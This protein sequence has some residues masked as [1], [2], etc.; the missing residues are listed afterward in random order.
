VGNP[1]VL[2]QPPRPDLSSFR[3]D[4]DIVTSEPCSGDETALLFLAV[5]GAR[6]LCAGVPRASSSR[7]IGVAA[8]ALGMAG[9]HVSDPLTGEFRHQLTEA[10]RNHAL[11]PADARER[12][13][14]AL[15]LTTD[16]VV[17]ARELLGDR[18]DDPE[19]AAGLAELHR[20]VAALVRDVGPRRAAELMLAA[21]AAEPEPEPA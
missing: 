6:Q 15:I 17:G 16:A 2:S 13:E 18:H 12:A 10:V 3:D 4:L 1:V 21:A 11:R 5:E 7:H 19:L 9:Y 14:E 20:A 8:Q